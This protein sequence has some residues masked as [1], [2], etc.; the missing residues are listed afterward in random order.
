[1]G[2]PW[3]SIELSVEKTRKITK[4]DI[5]KPDIV[6]DY[7]KACRTEVMRFPVSAGGQADGVLGHRR[8]LHHP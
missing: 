4:E 7:N 3:A 5:A 1:M 6:E 8:S 2:Y